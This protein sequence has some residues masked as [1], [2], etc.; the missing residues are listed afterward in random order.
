M[1]SK[2]KTKRTMKST[3]SIIIFLCL[4]HICF[5]QEKDSTQTKSDTVVVKPAGQPDSVQSPLPVKKQEQVTETPNSTNQPRIIYYQS[6]DSKEPYQSRNN[7]RSKN[8]NRNDVKTLAG[9]MNHSGGFGAL[10]FR[11][12][13]FEDQT[14]VLAGVRAGWIVNRTLGIGFEGHGI[15]PSAQFDGIDP[16]ESVV[17]LGG[18]GGMFLELI[19]FSNQVVHLT[20]PASAGAGWM[21]YNIDWENSNFNGSSRTVDEDI[22]WYVEPGA[23]IEMNISRNFRLDFGVSKRFT[24]DLELINTATNAFDNLNYYVTLKI[25]GF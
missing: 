2:L 10:S 12:T 4:A 6:Q 18:Y 24:Q 16:N 21:G 22:F 19:L 9:S 25:G 1:L 15:I 11:M 7:Y 14:M 3:L 5:S 8:N 23:N 20:F 17:A 13:E